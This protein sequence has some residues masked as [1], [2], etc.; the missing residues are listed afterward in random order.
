MTN[1]RSIADILNERAAKAEQGSWIPGTGE[2]P[3]FTR[4]RRRLLYCW[5]PSTG[6]K[7]YLDLDTDLL[8]S[9]EEVWLA[10]AV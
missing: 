1:T 7:A 9:D 2:E 3:I 10:L 6:R 5:Q 4:S 8:L